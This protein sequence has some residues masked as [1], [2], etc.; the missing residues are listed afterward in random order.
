MIDDMWHASFCDFL[1]KL[2]D[3]SC[4][5]YNNSQETKQFH[6]YLLTMLHPL[7]WSS[8]EQI[9]FA[10]NYKGATAQIIDRLVSPSIP[11]AVLAVPCIPAICKTCA[12]N[13]RRA[14][15]FD[16]WQDPKVTKG[17]H[18]F[19]L[20]TAVDES[21]FFSV[22]VRASTYTTACAYVFDEYECQQTYTV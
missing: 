1:K 18:P 17:R 3:P 6:P 8:M 12:A 20:Y 16:S 4:L 11:L 15:E 10:S 19:E 7:R 21:D 14:R 9:R 22:K 5:D 2:L 13:H